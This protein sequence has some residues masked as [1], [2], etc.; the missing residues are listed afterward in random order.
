MR[1][2]FITIPQDLD[3]AARVDGCTKIQAFVHIVL[4]VV[5]PGIAAGTILTFLYSW[6]EFL[7]AFTV[8]TDLTSMTIP[9]ST[10]LFV[11]DTSI[12]W[13]SMAAAAVVAT[14]PS[15]LVVFFFQRYIVVGLTGGLKG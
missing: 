3:E 11:G 9:V 7:F 10:F 15:A 2:F 1:N 13:A 14:I 12:Q 6:R 4:P 8:S 5:M